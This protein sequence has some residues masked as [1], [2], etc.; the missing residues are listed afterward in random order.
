MVEMRVN[1]KWLVGLET[2][3]QV[4][5]ETE[6]KR[7]WI[8]RAEP[9]NFDMWYRTQLP[10]QSLELLVAKRKWITS[11]YENIAHFTVFTNVGKTDIDL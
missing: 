6:R 3:K 8:A 2:L 11:G 5:R 4:S 10:N 1:K 9:N 7:Y